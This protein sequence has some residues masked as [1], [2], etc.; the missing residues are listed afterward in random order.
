MELYLIRHGETEWNKQNRLQGNID[1]PLSAEGIRMA[2]GA[3]ERLSEIHFN[4]IY[5]SPLS[6]AFTTAEIICKNQHDLIKKDDRLREISF[7]AGEGMYYS[8][9]MK[10]DSPYKYF[11][12][13]NRFVAVMFFFSAAT[14]IISFYRAVPCR[15]CFGIY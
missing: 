12:S 13:Y 4:K 10:S 9:W 3:A 6:R 1:V 7:G 8:E 11:F 15:S 14:L 5:S 2:E